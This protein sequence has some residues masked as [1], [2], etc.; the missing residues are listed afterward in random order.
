MSPIVT[1]VLSSF[2]I[3]PVAWLSVRLTL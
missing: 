3:V 1:F 2:V